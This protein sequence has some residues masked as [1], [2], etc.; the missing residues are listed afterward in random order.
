MLVLFLQ[1]FDKIGTTDQ[2]IKVLVSIRQ[3]LSNLDEIDVETHAVGILGD[4]KALSLFYL[5]SLNGS[6]SG[7]S[8]NGRPPLPSP[9]IKTNTNIL[10]Q[11]DYF[12]FFNI[13][14]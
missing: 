4:L 2:I 1:I 12:L 9:G 7:T 11:V 8:S 13:L 10:G 5:P 14:I 6:G 3:D